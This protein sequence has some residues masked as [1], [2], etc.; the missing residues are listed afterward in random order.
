MSEHYRK[1]QMARIIKLAF[2]IYH[3]P[4]EWTR[5][6]LAKTFGVNKATIQR[7]IN[8]L[9]DMGFEIESHTRRGYVMVT[10]IYTFL[11]IQD[12]KEGEIE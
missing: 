2:L 8:L 5:P 1:N 9:R 3:H 11:G 12:N 6:R 10:D 7:D 4:E